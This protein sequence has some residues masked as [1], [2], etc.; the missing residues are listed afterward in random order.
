M[1]LVGGLIAIACDF[2][3]AY[4]IAE[5]DVIQYT[6]IKRKQMNGRFEFTWYYYFGLTVR[7]GFAQS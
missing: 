7:S 4:C 5:S 6:P 1:N 3:H 2:P